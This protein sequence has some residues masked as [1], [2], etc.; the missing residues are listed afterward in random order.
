M[1]PAI[2]TFQFQ[3]C[4][5]GIY[6]DTVLVKYCSAVS[7][8]AP[9]IKQLWKKKKAATATNY[10]PHHLT[11]LGDARDIQHSPALVPP[12]SS[13]DIDTATYTDN[14]V[15]H[16]ALSHNLKMI[17]TQ[18][19]YIISVFGM[20]SLFVNNGAL[21]QSF[22]FHHT[23]PILIGFLLFNDILKPFDCFFTFYNN[24]LSR[25]HEYEA[26]NYALKQ[27]YAKELARSLIKLQIENLSSMDADWLYSAYHYSHPILSERLSAIGYQ[28]E[29]KVVKEK[30]TKSD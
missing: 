19:I 21:F 14:R 8:V 4:V 3:N 27:G 7:Y 23:K 28:P 12:Q 18:N 20:F 22:G 16:W 24:I 13:L 2:S 30:A 25:K 6:D 1:V 17:I 15:C 5:G 29:E 9:N 10:S 26:D 11:S